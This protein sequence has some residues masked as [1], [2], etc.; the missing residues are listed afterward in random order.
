MYNMQ[1]IYYLKLS[2]THI[3][4]YIIYIYLRL[5]YWLLV[6]IIKTIIPNKKNVPY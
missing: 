3:Y 6:Y 5:E 2:H 4:I 1:Y